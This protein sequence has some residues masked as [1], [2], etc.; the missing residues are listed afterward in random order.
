[1]HF[2]ST[3]RAGARSRLSPMCC[4][5]AWRPMAG[6]ICPQP[7]RSFSAPRS[8]ASRARATRTW[9]S[10][11]CRASPAAA[12]SDAELQ[13]DIEAAYA[14]FD[15]RRRSRRWS[16]IERRPLSAGA[17][18]RPHPRLQGYRAADPGPA[19]RPRAGA[20][21]RPRHRRRRDLGRYRLGGHRG[22]GRTAQYRCLRAASQGPGQRR[23]APPDDHQRAMPM[24]TISRW[25]AASTTRRAS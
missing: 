14:G 17:V 2:I 6:F 20:A 23:A 21:R 18:S 7:G 3:T 10:T 22:A 12:F 25:K 9:P 19:V 11:S 4:W 16:Q 24:S 1:M 5:R 13:D 8:P 15:A